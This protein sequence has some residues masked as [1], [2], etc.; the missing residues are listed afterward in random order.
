[1]K[2]PKRR[3]IA[4]EIMTEIGEKVMAWTTLVFALTFCYTGLGTEVSYPY[5]QLIL[6]PAVLRDSIGIWKW[7]LRHTLSAT[8][9][10]D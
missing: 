9:R 7:L 5:A 10:W 4:S 6:F 1:M 8:G 2:Q 3:K